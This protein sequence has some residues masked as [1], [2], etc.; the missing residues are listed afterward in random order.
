MQRNKIDRT[1]VLAALNTILP[2]VR[3]LD[4]SG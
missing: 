3:A 4:F 1:K 2:V